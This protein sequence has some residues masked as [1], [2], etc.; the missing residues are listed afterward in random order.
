MQNILTRW[1]I[2]LV[3]YEF[4]I[5]RKLK[6]N[7]HLCSLSFQICALFMYLFTH[8]NSSDCVLPSDGMIGDS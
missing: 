6:K 2:E 3:T 7:S 5:N 1:D 4:N 8:F